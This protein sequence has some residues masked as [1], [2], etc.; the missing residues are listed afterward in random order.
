MW[1]RQPGQGHYARPERERRFLLSAPPADLMEPR[2]IVD[3]YIENT[4][5][6]LRKVT[7]E[8][9]PVYKLGQKVRPKEDD[10]SVVMLTNIYLSTQEYERL[11]TLP[12]AVIRKMRYSFDLGQHPYVVDVF[13]DRLRGLVLSEEE[14]G[15]QTGHG[16]PQLPGLV[17]EVTA[18]DRF[19]GGALAHAGNESIRTM[20]AVSAWNGERERTSR[21]LP[22]RGDTWKRD[23]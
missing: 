12:A 15:E 16:L 22:Q 11:L 14:I 23:P 2:H 17:A 20:L 1:A 21:V 6:R 10:P 3:H 19:S 8:G 5:L 13:E 18:D 7:G 9:P 4:R